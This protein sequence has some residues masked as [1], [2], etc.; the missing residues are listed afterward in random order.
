M[1]M[2]NPRERFFVADTVSLLHERLDAGKR[3]LFEGAQGAMLD[4]DFGTYPY[5]TSSNA[6]IG[7]LSTG[8]GVPPSKIGRVIGV[9]KAYAT[10]VGEGPFPTE[11]LDA[12]GERLRQVGKEFGATTGRPRRCGWFDVPAARYA[13]RFC[14]VQSICLTKLDVLSGLDEVKVC[15][16]YQPLGLTRIAPTAPPPRAELLEE[17]DRSCA[18]HLSAFMQ[19]TSTLETICHTLPGW[20]E[21]LDDIHDEAQLP[22]AARDYVRFL[23]EKLGVPIDWLSV[24]KRRDQLIAR[25]RGVS[26][27]P[28]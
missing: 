8:T 1:L 7:G 19:Q 3:V 22:K 5:V 14:G 11:L 13:I 27:W 4:V 2:S 23:E 17:W 28:G 20:K 18:G 21:P 16:G 15:V 26:P 12:T 6:G 9:A 25:G 24:G 10:R